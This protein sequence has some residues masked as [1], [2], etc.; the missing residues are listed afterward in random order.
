MNSNNI[1]IKF[2]AKNNQSVAYDG[3]N[4]IGR[5]KFARLK[6]QWVITLTDVENI[7][8]CRTGSGL[9]GADQER[10][11]PI[12]RCNRFRSLNAD[13]IGWITW[14]LVWGYAIYDAYKSAEKMNMGIAVEDNMDI[15]NLFWW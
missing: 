15:H 13:L 2:E 12:L 3:N 5:C 8:H 10:N 11:S 9:L 7:F 14:L 1:E 4:A 6:G